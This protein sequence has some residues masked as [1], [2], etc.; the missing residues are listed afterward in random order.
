MT[1]DLEITSLIRPDAPA[2]AGRIEGVR[3]PGFEFALD[4]AVALL[5]SRQVDFYVWHEGKYV[6]VEAVVPQHGGHVVASQPW[7][8]TVPDGTPLDSLEHLE[9]LLQ[10]A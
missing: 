5:Q 3:G 7:L 10:P 9:T 1:Q 4:V 8:R 6:G 2:S